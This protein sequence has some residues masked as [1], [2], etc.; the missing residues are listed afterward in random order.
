MSDLLFRSEVEL[1]F[2]FKFLI[3]SFSDTINFGFLYKMRLHNRENKNGCPVS[4]SF[5]SVQQTCFIPKRRGVTRGVGRC[6]AILRLVARPLPHWWGRKRWFLSTRGRG[7]REDRQR[8]L[9]T[10]TK[11]S[12]D[13]PSHKEGVV[14]IKTPTV[15]CPVSQKITYE[16]PKKIYSPSSCGRWRSVVTHEGYDD[17]F[18]DELDS[19]RVLL[20]SNFDT[21]RCHRTERSVHKTRGNMVHLVH[22]RPFATRLGYRSTRPPTGEV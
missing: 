13:L 11:M 1:F 17:T 20:F 10:Q 19:L 5:L 14:F 4:G 16:Y 22:Q 12:I 2:F 21:S 18:H 15:V 9:R 8:R 3:F 6:L 7:A